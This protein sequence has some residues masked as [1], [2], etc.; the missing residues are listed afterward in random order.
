MPDPVTGARYPPETAANTKVLVQRSP[1]GARASW[2]LPT[3][4]RPASAT[5]QRAGLLAGAAKLRHVSSRG[6]SLS[7]FVIQRTFSRARRDYDPAEVDRH[8][9][10]VSQWFLSTDVGRTFTHERTELQERERAIAAKEA[11]QARS[12][13]GARLEA[14]ATLEGARRRAEAE[15]TAA[16]ERA[17]AIKAQAS[18]EAER[19]L[20]EARSAAERELI[21][22][23]RDREQRLAEVRVEAAELAERLREQADEQLRIYTDRRRREADRL[24][25]AARRERQA[26]PS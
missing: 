17:A 1:E 6:Q 2:L 3:P 15:A 9:E 11:E 8:L 10:L 5:R 22:A 12:I 13:E 25:H 26:P 4:V 23:R 19:I 16:D 7:M 18:A 20:A 14:E 21:A 24:A